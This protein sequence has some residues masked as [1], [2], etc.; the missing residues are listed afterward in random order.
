MH[1]INESIPHVENLNS[2]LRNSRN[3]HSDITSMTANSED[4][5]II[6]QSLHFDNFKRGLL[7]R[8]TTYSSFYV[9]VVCTLRYTMYETDL[10]PFTK[11]G[12]A[13]PHGD[14]KISCLYIFSRLSHN[15]FLHIYS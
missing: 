7:I 9:R 2:I 14:G 13:P 10:S 6:L 15:F 3:L 12:G 5:D 11:A 8:W 1:I 4:I